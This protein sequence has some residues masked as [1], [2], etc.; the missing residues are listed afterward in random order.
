MDPLSILREYVIHKKMDDVHYEPGDDAK[1]LF[2]D[3]Y[4]FDSKTLTTYR[5]SQEP[6]TFYDLE[7]LV[8][9]ARHLD[10]KNWVREY[11]KTAKDKNVAMVRMLDT[12]DLRAYLTGAKE[13]S[14]NIVPAGDD[15]MMMMIDTK[16]IEEVKGTKISGEDS[17]AA[18]VSPSPQVGSLGVADGSVEDAT[19]HTILMNERQLRNRNTML[20]I[21]GRSLKSVLDILNGLTRKFAAQAK[22]EEARQARKRHREAAEK[23]RANVVGP[24]PSGRYDRAGAADA[25]LRDMGAGDL[26]LQQVGFGGTE[27]TMKPV[28]APPPP[29]TAPPP[30]PPPPHQ[31]VASSQNSKRPA[32]RPRDYQQQRK[33]A[34]HPPVRPIILVP[35][36]TTKSLVN[37]LNAPKF[38]ESGIFTPPQEQ[39]ALGVQRPEKVRIER[40]VNGKKIKI[41]ILDREPRD[42]KDWDRVIAVVCLG[43]PWQFRSWP[44]P[45]ADKG[46]LVRTFNRVCGVYFHYAD[47]PIDANIK[48]WNV[49]TLGL[50]RHNRDGDDATSREF[51]SHLN[52]FL[53]A[54]RP[55]IKF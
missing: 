9:F 10:M 39:G 52:S 42:K 21:P 23:A 5:S 14:E 1:V 28:E 36:A 45:G 46:D 31:P 43:K 37:I 26:G 15:S 16:G 41:D 38:F 33:A 27:Q 40:E 55:D 22:H 2:G 8:L 4:A 6:K 48:Q 49:R 47:D 32:S 17:V 7:T 50:R 44:F 25:A 35:A 3:R 30:P 54:R 51:W 24:R 13:T 11:R 18:I 53:E 29:T 12:G 19:L 20:T 34:K